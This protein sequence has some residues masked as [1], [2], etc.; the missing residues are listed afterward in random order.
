MYVN[1]KEG[2][3]LLMSDHKILPRI[4]SAGDDYVSVDEMLIFA[5]GR[6]PVECLNVTI[7]NDDMFETSESFVLSLDVKHE[8]VPVNATV[9]ID[10]ID[11]ECKLHV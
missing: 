10:I 2:Q 3:T 5:P 9:Y 11:D 7:N 4:F 6:E 8:C 1:A